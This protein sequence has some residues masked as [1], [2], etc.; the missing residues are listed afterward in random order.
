M[1]SVGEDV[2]NPV[3]TCCPMEEGCWWV[4][5]QHPLRGGSCGE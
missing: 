3:V 4:G 1:A 5:G 2:L